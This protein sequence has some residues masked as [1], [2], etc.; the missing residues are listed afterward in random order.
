M[1]DD[2]DVTPRRLMLLAHMGR[3]DL[4]DV[5]K[6]AWLC[7]SCHKCEVRCPRGIDIPKTMEAIRQI[8]LRENENYIEPFE[9]PTETIKEAPQIAMISCFRKMTS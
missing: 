6:T 8:K 9:I 4:L 1:V 7:A 3:K 2:M 5:A